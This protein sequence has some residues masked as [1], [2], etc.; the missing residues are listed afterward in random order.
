M[1]CDHCGRPEKFNVLCPN[2]ERF[3]CTDCGRV[4]CICEPKDEAMS[5]LTKSTH[6]L[7]QAALA[8][9][10]EEEKRSLQARGRTSILKTCQHLMACPTAIDIGIVRELPPEER[11]MLTYV[12]ARALVHWHP[13]HESLANRSVYDRAVQHL[14]EVTFIECC[15]TSEIFTYEELAEIANA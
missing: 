8:K 2:C 4:F 10:T 14:A 7:A 1:N 11:R 12:L 13:T 6:K 9:A 3:V 5:Q 15:V